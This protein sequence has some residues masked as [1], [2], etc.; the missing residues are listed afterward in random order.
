MTC[1]L[2]VLFFV[3]MWGRFPKMCI[4]AKN[5]P[6]YKEVTRSMFLSVSAQKFVVLA[7]SCLGYYTEFSHL[8][9]GK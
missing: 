7:P 9:G 1:N 4:V 3:V 8:G 2:L 6:L 5:S